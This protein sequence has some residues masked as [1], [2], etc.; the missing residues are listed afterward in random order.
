M[1]LLRKL[2]KENRWLIAAIVKNRDIT[3]ITVK[4]AVDWKK[5]NS[6]SQLEIYSFLLEKNYI[7]IKIKIPDL[8]E[9]KEENE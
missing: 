8:F 2:A 5:I 7:D 1:N 3:R 4:K 9:V 6:I